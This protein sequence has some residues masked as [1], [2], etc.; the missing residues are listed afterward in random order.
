MGAEANTAV[1]S[2]PREFAEVEQA[3]ADWS[4]H[5]S[6]EVTITSAGIGET[7]ACLGRPLLRALRPPIERVPKS[8]I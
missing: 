6:S 2:D 1:K 4:L 8:F 3:D 5:T 7:R